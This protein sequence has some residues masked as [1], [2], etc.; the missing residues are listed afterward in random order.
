MIDR[1]FKETIKI[2][3]KLSIET[4]MLKASKIESALSV[5]SIA[6]NIASEDK[7]KAQRLITLANNIAN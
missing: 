7:N 5:L 6:A 4:D 1:V 2:A 3:S